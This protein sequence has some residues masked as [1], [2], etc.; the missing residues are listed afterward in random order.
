MNMIKYNF[1]NDGSCFHVSTYS[2][3]GKLLIESD[4]LYYDDMIKYLN[5]FIPESFLKCGELNKMD[6]NI[7]ENG[8]SDIKYNGRTYRIVNCSFVE[9]ELF[10]NLYGE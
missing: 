2:D 8:E 7:L 1:T 5:H 10:N 9:S 3:A 6:L 4:V